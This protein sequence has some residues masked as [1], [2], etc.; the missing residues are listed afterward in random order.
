ML[1]FEMDEFVNR[2]QKKGN[3]SGC[4]QAAT[5]SDESSERCDRQ[6]QIGHRHP[7]QQKHSILL[8]IGVT[9]RI[10]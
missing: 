8:A 10:P 5:G 6:G 9:P 7:R 1:L 2:F 3:I 4:R